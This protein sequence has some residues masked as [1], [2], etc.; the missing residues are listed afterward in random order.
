MANAAYDAFKQG[1]L[2]AE[3]DLNTAVIKVALVRGY[4]F[5]AAHATMADVTAA[6]GVINGTSAALTSPT[7]TGG[8]FDAADTTITTTNNNANHYLV[9]YQAS[10]VGGGADVAAASQKLIAYFDTGTGLPIVPGTG[11]ATITW[12]NTASRIIKVG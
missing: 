6:G 10:A 11:V 5:S 1:L 12:S 3:Y 9:V 2:N 7:I 8:V 4:T